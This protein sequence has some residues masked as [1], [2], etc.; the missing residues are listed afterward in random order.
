MPSGLR[1]GTGSEHQAINEMSNIITYRKKC[2]PQSCDRHATKR[3]VAQSPL[4]L[5]TCFPIK[6][7]LIPQKVGCETLWFALY[8]VLT[9]P[10]PD[11]WCPTLPYGNSRWVL[12]IIDRHGGFLCQQPCCKQRPC[13]ILWTDRRQRRVLARISMTGAAERT[14]DCL[15]TLSLCSCHLTSRTCGVSQSVRCHAGLGLSA[16]S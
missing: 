1:C 11:T 10:A 12:T 2:Q 13:E 8:S 4:F 16:W 9:L 14:R 6:T 15:G 3:Q 7:L 5:Q